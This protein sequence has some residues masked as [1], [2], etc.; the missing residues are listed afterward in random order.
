MEQIPLN[1]FKAMWDEV[2]ED[3]LRA[4]DRVGRSGWLILGEQT[5]AFERSLAEIFQ[6]PRAVG[7]ANGM[8]ALEMGL[9]A[10]G[11]A[12]GDL[13]LTTPLSAFASTL[14]IVRAG[15]VPVFVDVDQTGLMDLGLA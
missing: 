14:A 1:D 4:V 12:D 7:C 2:R 11:L 10:L 3:A 15:G 5:L 13:V 6:L 8:D 9:R